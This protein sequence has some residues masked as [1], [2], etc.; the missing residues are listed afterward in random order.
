MVGYI[1]VILTSAKSPKVLANYRGKVIG[2]K[3]DYTQARR[4]KSKVCG[5]NW[6]IISSLLRLMH[7]F[8]SVTWFSGV[9]LWMMLP[10][11]CIKDLFIRTPLVLVWM[12]YVKKK[13]WRIG[14]IVAEARK[15]SKSPVLHLIET[16]FVGD[17]RTLKILAWIVFNFIKINVFVSSIAAT[18]AAT[19]AAGHHL[20]SLCSRRV[21]FGLHS[22]AVVG[23]RPSPSTLSTLHLS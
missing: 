3:E 14:P 21:R 12:P 17:N 7:Y 8:I 22:G 19:A 4:L 5:F 2:R 9:N 13:L 6:C 23:S 1:L 16:I 15:G 18:T 11:I 10:Q 20:A